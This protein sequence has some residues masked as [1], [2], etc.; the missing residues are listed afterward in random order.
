MP[1]I[2]LRDIT[3]SFGPNPILDNVSFQIEDRE[4]LCIVGRNG[5]GKSTLLKLIQGEIIPDS[6]EIIKQNNLVTARLEQ[7]VPE[8]LHG[9][10]YDVIAGGLGEVGQLHSRY[11]QISMEL[12]DNT[13][14]ALLDEFNQLQ[15]QL[16][17]HNAWDLSHRIEAVIDR[18]SLNGDED[19]S[20]LSGGLKRRV[21]LGR[22]L[23]SDP[24]IILLDEPTNHLDIESIEWLEKF[25]AE[26][27]GTVVFI[28]HDRAFLQKLATRLL[29]IDRGKVSNYEC[30]FAQFLERKAHELEVEETHNKEFDKKLQQ[31]EAWIRQGIKARRTRNEGRVRSLK[32]LRLERQARQ[33]SMGK[34]DLHHNQ[35]QASGKL[36]LMA[37]KLSFAYEGKPIIREFS[38]TIMRGDKIG[39][40]GPNGIGKTTLIKLL[41]G[42]IQPDAGS[43]KQGTKLDIAYFDQLRSQLNEEQTVADNVSAGDQYVTINDQSIHIMSYLK[44]FLFTGEQVRSKVKLLSGGERNRLLLAKLLS[45]PANLLVLDEPTNDLDLDTLELLENLMVDYTGT[46]LLVSHDRSFLNNVVTSTIAFEGDGKVVEYVGGYDDWLRQRNTQPEV[47]KVEKKAAPKQDFAQ[48]KAVRAI[49]QKIERLEA[50]QATLEEEFAAPELYEAGKEKELEGL[51]KKLDEIKAKLE[52]LTKEWEQLIG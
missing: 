40:I 15:Q 5:M 49:E 31:E 44:S 33:T 29:E 4:R 14:N 39:I 7:N 12:S 37:D 35:A 19:F 21:L 22:L 45:Q 23:M 13:P 52:V 34:V 42:E 8:D 46:L 18:L 9:S 1:L 25:I 41:L 10:V 28:S 30:D 16:E 2:S 51:Q 11:H 38:T 36:V 24:N 47:K 48:Q 32:K 6:G 3:L 50:Q 43:I 17:Q 27:N 20:Q 26:F